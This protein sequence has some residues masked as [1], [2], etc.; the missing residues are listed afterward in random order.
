MPYLIL[1]FVSLQLVMSFFIA[2]VFDEFEVSPLVANKKYQT[3][4]EC[5]CGCLHNLISDEPEMKWKGA[6]NRGEEDKLACDL[7]RGSES[8]KEN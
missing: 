5:T 2:W 3:H 8:V 4:S 6:E 7:S 1:C